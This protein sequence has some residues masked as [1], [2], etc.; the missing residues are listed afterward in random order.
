[1]KSKGVK[2]GLVVLRRAK[3]RGFSC[4]FFFL[5]LVSV[6]SSVVMVTSYVSLKYI[7]EEE[8]IFET[9]YKGGD[10]VDQV[11]YF[12]A[13]AGKYQVQILGKCQ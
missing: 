9:S 10:F 11:E 6:S 8:V 4:T 3:L 2:K 1:M 5:F 12:E 13:G 7:S